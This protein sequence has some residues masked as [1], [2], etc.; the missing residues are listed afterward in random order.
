M[1]MMLLL[2]MMMMQVRRRL[3]DLKF[4]RACTASMGSVLGENYI[5]TC[6]GR[7]ELYR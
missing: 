4:P 6:S 1:M 5:V 3:A 2:M 7:Y